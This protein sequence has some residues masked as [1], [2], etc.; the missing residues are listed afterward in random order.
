MKNLDVGQSQK[1]DLYES[2][3]ACVDIYQTK[4]WSRNYVR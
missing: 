3:H 1:Q 2:S 4:L